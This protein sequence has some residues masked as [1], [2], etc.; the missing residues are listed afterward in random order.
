MVGS[1]VSQHLL[2]VLCGTCHCH[3]GVKGDLHVGKI[4]GFRFWGLES[5]GLSK[6]V[7]EG[8]KWDKYMA[9]TGSSLIN[10]LTGP[11]D[12]P[13]TL[14]ISSDGHSGT[15]YVCHDRENQHESS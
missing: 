3:L 6:K 4:L 5:G 14:Q 8:D 1:L 10:L 13:S 15:G 11:P 7:T 12:P 9:Y 2:V